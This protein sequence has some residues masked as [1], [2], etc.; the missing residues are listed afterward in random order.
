MG[1]KQ[2]AGAE[3]PAQLAAPLRGSPGRLLRRAI[4]QSGAWSESGALRGLTLVA[5]AKAIASE[6]EDLGV[7][8]QAIGDGRGDGGVVENVAPLGKGSVGGDDRTATQA[9]TRRD[10]LIKQIGGLLVEREVTEFVADQQ[11]RVGVELELANQGVIDLR[12]GQLVEHIHGGGEQDA[13]IGL[14][15]APA[16]DL[17]EEGLARSGITNQD[18]VGALVEEV[19]I[20]KA[21][22]ARFV[23][24]PRLV[25]LEQE[26]VDGML[27]MQAGEVE[28]P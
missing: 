8:H 6:Q 17:R 7:L 4:A 22:D 10:D 24:Q 21:E 14:T 19:Q 5:F 3:A 9:V 12:G 28:T 1:E 15:C 20:Q 13:T 25:M 16:D 18:D 2:P 27:R 23:L 26:R 11:R